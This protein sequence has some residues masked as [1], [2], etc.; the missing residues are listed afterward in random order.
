MCIKLFSGFRY[1]TN[2]QKGKAFREKIKQCFH[3]QLNPLR[4]V[5]SGRKKED[6]SIPL[7]ASTLQPQK[8]NQGD[9][10]E[11]V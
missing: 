11:Y 7:P 9:I 6:Y 8:R 10:L 4:S 1:Q 5:L 2:T 3:H